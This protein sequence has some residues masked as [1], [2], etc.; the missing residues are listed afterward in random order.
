M[1]KNNRGELLSIVVP[2]YN[3][4]KWLERCLDS[5]LSQSYRNVEVICVNDAEALVRLLHRRGDLDRRRFGV[6]ADRPR[7]TGGEGE[8]AGK[9]QAE[10]PAVGV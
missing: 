8:Q 6:R 7:R 10:R 5:L 3:P 1:E 2:V 9:G 4:E